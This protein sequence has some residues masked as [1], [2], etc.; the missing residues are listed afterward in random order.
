MRTD[1]QS[2]PHL[3]PDDAMTSEGEERLR[4]AERQYRELFDAIPVGLYRATADGMI[5][6]ANAALLEMLGYASPGD[7][8]G[9]DLGALYVNP[10]DRERRRL[11]IER[12]GLVRDF[13]VEI[14]RTDG[15][16]FWAEEN[17]RA[18]KDATGA[19]QNLQGSLEDRSLRRRTEMELQARARQQAAVAEIGQRALL[20]RPLSDLLDTTAA[21]V[22][23]TLGVEYCD[24]M[25]LLPDGKT[26]RLRAAFGIPRELIGS[27]SAEVSEEFPAGKALLTGTPVVV[28]S[29][30]HETTLRPAP[31]ARPHRLGST[32]AVPIYGQ[33]QGRAYGVLAV[34]DTKPY[35]FGEEDVHFL[36]AV[37]NVLASASERARVEAAQKALEERLAETEKMRALGQLAAGVAHDINNNLA[38][39]LGPAQLAQES[40]ATSPET[41]ELLSDLAFIERAAQDA[42][43]TV[44]RLLLFARHSSGEGAANRE[45]VAPDDLLRDVVALTRPRWRDQ[46]QAEG[47]QNT[48]RLEP[49]GAPEVLADPAG[50]REALVNLVTNAIDAMPEGGTLTLGTASETS[51]AGAIA[52]L[53][54]GDTGIGMDEEARTRLFEPFFTTKP[55]GKGTGLGLAMV[56]GIVQELRGTI[57]VESVPGRGT[58]FTIRLPAASE[59]G[60]D[61]PPEVA[62]ALQSGPL[63]VL[64][65]E[66]EAALRHV[67]VRMLER[68]GHAV[69]AVPTAEEALSILEGRHAPRYDLLVTDVGLPGQSGWQ[70]A[71]AVRARWPALKL[72]VATGWG[73]SV[74]DQDLEQ[75]GI[76]RAQLVPKPYRFD[77]L[78]RTIATLFPMAP[79]A[80]RAR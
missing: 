3:M 19:I 55:V 50:L 6:D 76:G 7:L 54:V 30:S 38:A 56:R 32:A 12:E 20:R 1:V 4:A 33:S 59:P 43:Q 13:E 16:S 15:T 48:V 66:D 57:E 25:E 77:D 34:H 71:H 2:G 24:V 61:G 73:A 47:R 49:G 70:L 53:R 23:R 72:I 41:Q 58:T 51:A 27:A 79:P 10:Q 64:V 31:F 80:L 17:C 5:V 69:T 75:V 74:T 44:R 14:R 11:L 22:A 39:I 29:W 9:I 68:D 21:K 37:A 26:I 46:A 60:V 42:A 62:S 65:V 36:E 40:V 28:A 63:W 45:L 52:V 18:L 67:V 8:A 35:A 78:R